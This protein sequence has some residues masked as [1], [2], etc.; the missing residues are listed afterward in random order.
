V[1]YSFFNLGARWGG[2]STPRSGRFTP[3][4]DTRYPLYRRLGGLRGRTRRVRK[5]SHPDRP[6]LSES[7]YRLSYPGPLS[8][9][10]TSYK[11]IRTAPSGSESSRHISRSQAGRPRNRISIRTQSPIQW[12]PALYRQ[13]MHLTTRLHLLPRLRI[14]GATPPPTHTPSWCA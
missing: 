6:A 11:H 12:L 7:L 9:H 1:L 3:G 8:V 10:C 14:S 13:G 2:W 4:K 5:I